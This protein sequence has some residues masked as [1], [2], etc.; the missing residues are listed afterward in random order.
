MADQAQGGG[1]SQSVEVT[2]RTVEEAVKRALLQLNATLDDVD[3]KIVDS[4]VPRVLRM[5]SKEARVRVSL[6]DRPYTEEHPEAAAE[7]VGEELPMEAT[8][9]ETDDDLEVT[10]VERPPLVAL[11]RAPEAPSAEAPPSGATP[12]AE[13][14]LLVSG[15]ELQ[16][17]AEDIIEGLL[18]RLGFDAEFELVEENPLG[19]DVVSE[20]DLGRLI[21]RQGETLRAFAYV[22]NLMVS[23]QLGRPCRVSIDVG[24]YRRQRSERLAELARTVA[25]EVRKTKEPVT[26]DAMSAGERRS[27]HLALAED[28]DVRTYSIGQGEDRRV[29]ISPKA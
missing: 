7:A 14:E 22:V 11:P 18:D 19:Y 6:R 25:D 5:G 2:G 17:V 10:E 9:E 24:G 28:P 21:G 27:I 3:I 16:D 29:V 23:R 1:T 12:A 4:R 15:E 20:S 13:L 26:L 8:D